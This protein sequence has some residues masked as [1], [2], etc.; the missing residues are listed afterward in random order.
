[1]ID[2]A[3]WLIRRE[4]TGQGALDD[5]VTSESIDELCQIEAAGANALRRRAAGQR[6]AQL[7]VFARRSR[8]GEEATAEVT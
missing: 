2:V 7:R 1:M 5:D 3:R 6:H 8:S 4:L